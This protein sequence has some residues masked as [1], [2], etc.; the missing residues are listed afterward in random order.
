MKKYNGSCHCGA[1]KYEGKL[2]MNEPVCECNCSHD[3]IKGMLLSFG[4]KEDFKILTGED[5]LT[6]YKFNKMA[7]AHLFCK[8]C[9]VQCFS[10]EEPHR[11]GIAI[12]VKTLHD[13]N[14]MTLKKAPY[15]GENL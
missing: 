1:V 5:N 12:N 7:I 2:D 13:I 3:E 15:D 4:S 10:Y 11:T 14:I 6:E 8:T 9:G